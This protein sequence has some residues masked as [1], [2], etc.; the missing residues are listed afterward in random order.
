M[1]KTTIDTEK[2]NKD[3]LFTVW[4]NVRREEGRKIK[5][6]RKRGV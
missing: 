2:V 1:C 6:A 5:E 3:M 4:S